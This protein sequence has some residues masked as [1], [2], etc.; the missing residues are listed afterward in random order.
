MSSSHAAHRRS[1]SRQR[2]SA[3]QS[4]KLKHRQHSIDQDEDADDLLLHRTRSQ[5]ITVAESVA[6]PP[7]IPAL[8]I[9]EEEEEEEEEETLR[10]EAG[11]EDGG[12]GRGEDDRGSFTGAAVAANWPRAVK[13][14]VLLC[15]FL[16]SLSFGGA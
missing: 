11:N 5:E 14:L 8:G 1:L 10:E 9:A 6:V 2:S 4:R 12:G 15:A 3:S 7:D 13:Y 16:T